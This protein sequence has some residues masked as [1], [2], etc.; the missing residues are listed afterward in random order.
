MTG[1][2]KEIIITHLIIII[3]LIKN[4]IYLDKNMNKNS[5]KIIREVAHKYLKNQ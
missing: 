3:I 4:F 1:L 2:L 5:S